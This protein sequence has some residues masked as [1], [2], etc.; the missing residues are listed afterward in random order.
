MYLG[1]GF[2]KNQWFP[3]FNVYGLFLVEDARHWKPNVTCFYSQVCFFRC[4]GPGLMGTL[5]DSL[6]RRRCH[7]LLGPEH[8]S[9][10]PYVKAWLTQSMQFN[11][12]LTRGVHPFRYQ[13]YF[14]S[15][16]GGYSSF[17]L[18]TFTLFA[19]HEVISRSTTWLCFDDILSW[20]KQQFHF[21]KSHGSKWR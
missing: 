4:K 18:A 15:E 1:C 2:Q 6:G 21:Y 10:R 19:W 20:W 17:F 8:G 13:I 3:W 16:G 11:L 7:L 9:G 14:L 5:R 12:F